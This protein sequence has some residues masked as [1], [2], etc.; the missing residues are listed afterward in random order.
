ME[1]DLD[2]I[3]KEL[4]FQDMENHAQGMRRMVKA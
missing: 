4:Q 1:P 2:I 3:A